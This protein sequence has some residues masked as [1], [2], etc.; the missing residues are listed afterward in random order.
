[1]DIKKCVIRPISAIFSV[2][3]CESLINGIITKITDKLA[4]FT[5]ASNIG[6]TVPRREMLFMLDLDQKN[7]PNHETVYVADLVSVF[8]NET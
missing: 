6:A 7:L 4:K 5:L 1:M 2:L 8:G 3:D